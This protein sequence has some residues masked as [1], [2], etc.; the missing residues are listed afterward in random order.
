MKSSLKPS[1]LVRIV[2][3][4]NLFLISVAGCQ[5]KIPHCNIHWWIFE[6]IIYQRLGDVFS[7][8]NVISGIVLYDFVI[9]LLTSSYNCYF[10]HNRNFF[11]HFRHRS[12]SC[13]VVICW[14]RIQTSSSPAS[15][16]ITVISGIS[17]V[18]VLLWV[19]SQD[20]FSAQVYVMLLPLTRE[21]HLLKTKE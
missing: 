3:S 14:H 13:V 9:S 10:H 17:R 18:V 2:F 11:H 19:E 8:I 16:N 15:C 4:S 1:S 12:T 20:G 5:L 21:L 6:Y 7:G